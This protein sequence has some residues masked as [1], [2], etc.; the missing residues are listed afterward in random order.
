M[1][2]NTV[3]IAIYD[4]PKNPR[5]LELIHDGGVEAGWGRATLLSHGNPP[6]PP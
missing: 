3:G 2:G 6:C 4:H 1:N 5:L